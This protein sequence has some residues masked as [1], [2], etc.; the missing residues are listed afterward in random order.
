MSGIPSYIDPTKPSIARVY[1]AFLSGTDNYEV[2][3]EVV[4]GVMKAAPEAADLA[5]ENRAFLIRACRFLAGEAGVTQY[6]DCGSGLPT[7]ENTHQVVQQVD[8]DSRVV[9]VDNDP[10]VL[11][12]SRA[13]LEGSENAV[14]VSEDIFE[15]ERLLSNELVRSHLDWDKPIALLHMGTLHHYKHEETRTRKDIMR[16]YIDAL[17]PGSYVALS[18]FLD[19]EDEYSETARMMESMFLHSMMGSGT[20]STTD[21][22]KDLFN[23]LEMVD[24]GLVRCTDWRRDD[25]Q[26]EQNAAQRC[27]AGGV[28][29]KP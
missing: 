21:E 23:G 22:L 19:P 29:R 26:T 1:D 15:P 24:P 28:A 13:L 27:I 4:R 10:L 2:D 6:L 5:V 9:Y 12:H 20:F 7:A 18:H 11:A 8:S 25:P 14:I 3:R 17:P 16:A